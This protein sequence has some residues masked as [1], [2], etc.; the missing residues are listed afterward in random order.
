MNYGTDPTYYPQ[1]SEPSVAHPV[2]PALPAAPGQASTASGLIVSEQQ[3][4]QSSGYASEQSGNES[5]H[6]ALSPNYKAEYEA[7]QATDGVSGWAIRIELF[8]ASA[9]KADLELEGALSWPR[10]SV[11]EISLL[12]F[13][14]STTASRVSTSNSR[15]DRQSSMD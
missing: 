13:R 9:H 10:S 8:L 3:S 11:K 14:Q 6:S 4:E 5:E 2:A 1:A 12:H 15:S 7:M